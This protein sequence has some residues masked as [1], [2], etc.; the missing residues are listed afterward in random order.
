VRAAKASLVDKQVRLSPGFMSELYNLGQATDRTRPLCSCHEVPLLVIK[1]PLS[2]AQS[3]P[4]IRSNPYLLNQGS[5]S[6]RACTTGEPIA[7]A[8]ATSNRAD[9]TSAARTPN[10]NWFA[11]ISDPNNATPSALPVC[12][13]RPPRR[14][15]I[16]QLE[17][18]L[19]TSKRTSVNRSPH[20]RRVPSQSP[21]A[22]PH[23]SHAQNLPGV[24]RCQP[25]H[26]P[27][28]VVVHEPEVSCTCGNCDPARLVRIGEAKTEVLEKIPAR[29]K[30]IQHVRPKYAC[31]ICEAVFQA[32]APELPIE[33]GRPGPGLLANVA[34]SKNCDGS[35]SIAV[36]HPRT[37]GH[38][39]RPGHRGRVDGTCAWWVMPLAERIGDYVTG[40]E[41]IWTDDTPI[42]TLAPGNGKTR[43]SRFWCHAVDP[44]PYAGPGPPGRVLSLQP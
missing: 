25:A 33:K 41:V 9:M 3:R 23:S 24:S 21:T 39:D 7:I 2:T 28:E 44:R 18:R 32:P 6:L 30:V 22:P 5:R 12:R 37:R 11:W 20:R 29:F 16:A 1:P 38:R 19:G 31:R 13:G 10:R 14:S 40:Q 15:W 26:L 17:M 8:A 4:P 27:R 36:R 35:R 43:V 34:V 42:R